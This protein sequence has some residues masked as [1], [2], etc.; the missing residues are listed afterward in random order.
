MP[1]HPGTELVTA[2]EWTTRFAAA[3][4]VDPPTGEELEALL[5]LAA[6]A[7]H[8]SQ[9]KAAPI[10]CWLVARAAV[11]PAAALSVG[12]DLA[13]ELGAARS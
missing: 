5:E 2:D 11:P 1:E 12:Q 3:L 7:A 6:V 10:A 9:R 8:A 4:G 13:G